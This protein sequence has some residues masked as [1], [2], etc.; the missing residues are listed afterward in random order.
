M[1]D[2]VIE[3]LKIVDGKVTLVKVPRQPGDAPF[4][5]SKDLSPNKKPDEDRLEW[6]RWLN[7]LKH[8]L[9]ILIVGRRGSGK[10]ALGYRILQ[11]LMLK[12]HTYVVGFPQ[13]A[14]KL[15]PAWVGIVPFLED[16]PP[17]S[18]VLIDESY[19]LFHSR[20]SASERA[21]ILSN[22]INLSRQR[23]QTLIFV[24]Q[25]AR[26]IDKNIT[27][28]VDVVIFKNPG[29]FQPEFER[30]ELRKIAEEAKRMFAAISI[31]EKIKWSYVYAP[32]SDFAGMVGN[33][34]PSFWTPGLS[35]AY[36][37]TTPN[38][39][40][41]IPKKMPLE[42]KKKKARELL[43]RSGWSYLSIA[44]YFGVVKSTVYNWIH[45][46]PYQKKPQTTLMTKK[47]EDL[48]RTQRNR[49]FGISR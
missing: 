24:T 22:L 34:L 14:R 47:N 23:E 28:S 31:K 32:G 25:E 40:M 3:K 37:D 27:S 39:E 2:D 11:Y 38:N 8:P 12:G 16:V 21:R 30:T 43:Y 10:S 20:A 18:V 1:S 17:K 49:A 7:L 9:V 26:Q 35:R 42:Q 33:S 36:A 15:L 46:Y 4:Q 29:I 45:D 41:V 13:K 48:F 5:P 44:N 6:G 19:N